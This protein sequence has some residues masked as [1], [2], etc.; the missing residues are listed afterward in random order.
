MWIRR[1][2]NDRVGNSH[3]YSLLFRSIRYNWSKSLFTKRVM[4]ENVVFKIFKVRVTRATRSLWKSDSLFLRVIRFKCALFTNIF[5]LVMPKTKERITLV[6]LL[7]E[8][9]E[10]FSALYK[11]SDERD[12]LRRSLQREWQEHFALVALYQ[13]TNKMDSLSLPFA[14]RAMRA[15]HTL[16][17][18]NRSF[19]LKKRA[20]CSKNQRANSQTL[21]TADPRAALGSIRIRIQCPP[22]M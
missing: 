7:K 9:W 18:A 14:K 8:W 11:K 10:W 20:I 4:G 12:S 16:K 21:Y 3:F 1:R 2:Y 5:P 15:I 17:R 6:S 22:I 19:A 13:K